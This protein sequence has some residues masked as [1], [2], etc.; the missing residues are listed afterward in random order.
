ML[1]IF[2]E[3]KE[4]KKKKEGKKSALPAGSTKPGLGFEVRRNMPM[5]A[6]ERL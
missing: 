1:L 4:E 5:T 6:K 3:K 2:K